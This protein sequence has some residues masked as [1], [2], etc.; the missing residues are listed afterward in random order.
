MMA[1]NPLARAQALGLRANRDIGLL[2]GRLGNTRHPN[3]AVLIAYRAANRAMRDVIRSGGRPYE[4]RE[5]TGRLRQEVRAGLVP[6][7]RSAYTGGAANARLQTLA[8]GIAEPAEPGQDIESQVAAAYD[9]IDARIQSQE[10]SITALLLSGSDPAYIMGDESRQG[11]LRA[12]DVLLAGAFWL[13]GL[14]WRGFDTYASHAGGGFSKQ[15]VAAIDER[16]TDCCLR[17]HGQIKPFDAPFELTGYPRLADYLDWPPFH[18]WCRSSGVLYLAGF[19]DGLTQAMQESAAA[20][21]AERAA[22]LNKYRHPADAFI[23]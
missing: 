6:V 15:V 2:F 23:K 17:A 1:D 16:T 8:Y 9:V 20:A 18:H 10:A 7:L 22:G 21:L 13:A 12:S 14:W 4:A 11:V 5:V 19:D 3:S